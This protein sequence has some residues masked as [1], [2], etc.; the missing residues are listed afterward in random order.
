MLNKAAEDS[1]HAEVLNI[2][3]KAKESLDTV[4]ISLNESADLAIPGYFADKLP[5]AAYEEDKFA[6]LFVDMRGSTKRAERIGKEKTFLTM[7]VYLPTIIAVVQ[8]HHGYTIDLMGDGVMA[9]FGGNHTAR[10]MSMWVKDAGLCGESLLQVRESIIN[11]ILRA[12]GIEAVDFGV[13][14]DYGKVIVTK[15]GFGDIIDVKA[16]GDCI[17]KASKYSSVTNAVKVGKSIKQHWPIGKN[18]RIRFEGTDADG[19]IMKRNINKTVRDH[20]RES[21]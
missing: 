9:L 13:G 3:N 1:I 11:D 17:N 15:I 20:G 7:H 19:Y 4:E 6:V 12:D 14:I 10:A 5:F 18:G 2:Y 16:F 8:K 21:P